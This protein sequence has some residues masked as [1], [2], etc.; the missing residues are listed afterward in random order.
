MSMMGLR[1]L[2]VSIVLG[3]GLSSAR[4]DAA[5]HT[6]RFG[7]YGPFTGPAAEVGLVLK[8]GAILAAEQVNAAGGIL[9]KKVELVFGDDEA[10]P[11]AGV[12]ALERMI[13]RDRVHIVGGG[14]HSS[15]YLA[16]M[17]AAAKYEVPIISG[18]P[19]SVDISKKIEKDPK[20]Y[21]MVFKDAY[22]ADAYGYGTADFVSALQ[23]SGAYTPKNKTYVVIGEDTD[24]TRSSIEYVDDAFQKL[25]WKR[26]S[27][28]I[29]KMDQADFLPQVVKIKSLQPGVVIAIQTGI[30]SAASLAK[31]F[32]QAKIP[33]LLHYFYAPSHPDFVKLAGRSSEGVTYITGA[34]IPSLAKG[35]VEAYKKRFKEDPPLNAAIQHDVMMV[36]FEAIKRAGS[37]DGRKI[38]QALLQ[39]RYTGTRGLHVFDQAN[40]TA[41]SGSEHLP[42][43]NLQI[44]GGKSQ[45]VFPF[46]YAEK[47]FVKP[48]WLK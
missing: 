40:H 45:M 21:W 31:S 32:S 12:S 20:K 9:G 3:L 25:G 38:A 44:Q 17:E 33:A 22:G 41:K 46:A 11:E 47:P 16:M 27:Y 36:G 19:V 14:V 2:A 37:L 7:V 8:N 15:V 18:G 30:A 26:V 1:F 34:M 43:V 10:K 39:T 13:A 23:K 29:V 42:A 28:E 24:F 6:I 5:D 4:V 48:D 35:F